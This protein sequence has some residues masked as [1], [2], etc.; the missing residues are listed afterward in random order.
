[1]AISREEVLEAISSMSVLDLSELIKEMEEKF[2]VS[3]AAMAVAAAPASGT[4][5]AAAADS[6]EEQTEFTVIL[7]AAGEKKVESIKAVRAITGLGLKEAKELVDGA[8]KPLKEGV[9]KEEKDDI[10]KQL[11]AAGA[12]AEVK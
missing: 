9:S 4:G 8:P 5:G 12:K 6:S 1:M 2:G 3:A 10:V 11:E 7:A